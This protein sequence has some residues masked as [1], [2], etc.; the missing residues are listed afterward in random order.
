MAENTLPA[1][2]T[3]DP[4]ENSEKKQKQKQNKQNTWKN[5]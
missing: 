4:W 2:A 5:V 1:I 3:A